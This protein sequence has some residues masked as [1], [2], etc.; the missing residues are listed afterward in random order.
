MPPPI[1]VFVALADPTRCRIIEILD[2]G[3]QPVHLLAASFSIS[4]P[5]I[6]RHLRVLKQARLISEK[7][8]G[9]ENLYALHRE[10]LKPAAKWLDTLLPR[11]VHT[12]PSPAIVEQRPSAVRPARPSAPQMN[13]DF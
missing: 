3:P 10:K 5:A 7:K 9:R 4:R 1:S 6:S 11:L 12:V 2:A 8:I 13:F